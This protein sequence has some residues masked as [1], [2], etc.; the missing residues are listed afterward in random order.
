MSPTT[1]EADH[2]PRAKPEGCGEF[3]RS[4]VTPLWPQS[5]YQFLYQCPPLDAGVC[6][7][8]TKRDHCL[9]KGGMPVSRVD[10]EGD[11]DNWGGC[12]ND[13]EHNILK[14][15]NFLACQTFICI[16]LWSNL[17]GWDWLQMASSVACFRANLCRRLPVLWMEH[18]T[19][20]TQA[21][22][23]TKAW[24][25]MRNEDNPNDNKLFSALWVV[26]NGGDGWC[27]T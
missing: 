19:F 11:A 21:P 13:N 6:D 4:L 18:Q 26:V 22:N 8:V 24:K 15:C 9:V 12:N 3:P 17:L 23:I 20:L 16:W 1:W 2:S 14:H 5:W 25:Q 27:S 7:R 10:C